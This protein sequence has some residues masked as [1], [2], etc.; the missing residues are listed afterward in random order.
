MTPAE[1][2]AVA[3]AAIA[4]GALV[5]PVPAAPCAPKE[6]P[7]RVYTAVGLKV[8]ARWTPEKRAAHGA[9]MKQ[10]WTPDA[11]KVH[12][13]RQRPILAAA[14]AILSAKRNAA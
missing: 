1:A 2:K 8:L 12:A 4:R 11:R 7:K 3:Q 5:P 14:R 9:R 10:L 13:E 6:K